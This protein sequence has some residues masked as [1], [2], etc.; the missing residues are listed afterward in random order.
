VRTITEADVDAQY[1]RFL[2]R[3]A[4]EVPKTDEPAALGDLITANLQFEKEGVLLSQA[5]ELRFRLFPELRLQDG[6]IPD[7]GTAL[8]GARPNDVREARVEIGTSATDPALRGQTIRA[9]IQVLD[10]KTLRLPEVDHLFLAGI[11]FESV[12]E[13]REAL[14]GV[15]ERRLEY[16]QRRAMRQSLLDQLVDQTPF[17]LPADL[18]SRQEKTTLRALVSEMRQAGYGDSELR[19]REAELRANAH[20]ATLRNLKEFF[21]LAK[22]ADAEGIKVE[23]DDVDMEIG[24][25]ALRSDESPRRVRARIEKE[26]LGEQLGTQILE[27]KAI[28]KI[29]ESARI[30]DVAVAEAEKPVETIDEAV[31]EVPAEG[32]PDEAGS[33]A[34]EG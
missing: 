10:V 7:L 31:S 33:P 3:Y 32:A 6:V 27:R 9:V 21:L 15:L 5:K 11:G 26:G 20:E 8:V 18:V 12:A 19:A 23:D 14:R 13:L 2:E 1:A 22:I 24:R 16:E 30:E 29:L 17:D 34:A 25:I 4:Q 28:D